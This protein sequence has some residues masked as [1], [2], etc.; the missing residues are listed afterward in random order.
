MIDFE[1][2]L[3]FLYKV[4]RNGFILA[5]LFFIAVYGTKQTI[6]WAWCKPII[7]FYF[8]YMLTEAVKHYGIDKQ[9]LNDYRLSG[10]KGSLKGTL[11]Y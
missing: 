1:E 10:K 7:L 4:L 9:I 11:F 3:N 2:D 5:G 6:S 8:F